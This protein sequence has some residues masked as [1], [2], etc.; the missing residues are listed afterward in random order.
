MASTLCFVQFREFCKQWGEGD[1]LIS[2]CIFARFP[3]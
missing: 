3:G 1:E 2:D